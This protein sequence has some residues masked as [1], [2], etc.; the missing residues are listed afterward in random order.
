MADAAF[1]FDY[2]AAV[3]FTQFGT[4]AKFIDALS[5]RGLKPRE[6]HRLASVRTLISTG[7]PL[8]PESYDYVYRDIKR[9]L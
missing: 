1:L 7:S 2:F 4:S 6:T 5:K 8:V 9:D 3:R